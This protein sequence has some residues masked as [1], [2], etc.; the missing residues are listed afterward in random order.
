MNPW[1]A[2]H[3]GAF[4]IWFAS[5]LH[6]AFLLGVSMFGILLLGDIASCHVFVRGIPLLFELAAQR[7]FATSCCLFGLG[8]RLVMLSSPKGVTPKYDP[9]SCLL[10]EGRLLV[11]PRRIP[12]RGYQFS[13]ASLGRVDLLIMVPKSVSVVGQ[14]FHVIL[15]GS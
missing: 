6:V 13:L 5:S 15:G 14:S 10:T 4:R 3:R 2:C 8:V 11:T 12:L 9:P 1:T 7:K